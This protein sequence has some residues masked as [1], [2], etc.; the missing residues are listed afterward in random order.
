MITIEMIKKLREKTSAGVM[1]CRRA[2]EETKSD[3]KKAEAL[4][5]KWGVE[6]AEKKQ[7][8]VTKSGLVESYIHAGGK[9]G[10]L[11][12]INCETDFVAK[13]EDFQKLAHEL[14]LQIASMNPKDVKALLKQGYIRDP[15]ITI[16]NL[17]KQVI[18]KLGENITIARFQR[19]QLGEK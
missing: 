6:R 17:V 2:L 5:K 12:E 18:G 15:A 4:L 7:D 3:E 10:V 16:E 19:F 11:L 8:R 9:V 1:N 13:T 14:C